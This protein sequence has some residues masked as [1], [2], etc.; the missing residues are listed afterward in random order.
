MKRIIILLLSVFAFANLNAQHKIELFDE[1][2]FVGKL[3][4]VS[5]NGY[6]KYKLTVQPGKYLEKLYE[7]NNVKQGNAIHLKFTDTIVGVYGRDEFKAL[8][9]SQIK[10]KV[11]GSLRHVGKGKGKHIEFLVNHVIEMGLDDKKGE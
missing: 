2:E 11:T 1:Y 6:Y 7:E 9:N 10:L 5:N 8:E 4:D 3:V